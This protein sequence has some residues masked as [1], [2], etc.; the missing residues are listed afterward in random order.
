MTSAEEI[1]AVVE[2]CRKAMIDL[3]VEEKVMVVDELRT[4]IELELAS[5]DPAAAPSRQ[6]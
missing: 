3:L 5:H 6:H 1:Q 4:W 2:A